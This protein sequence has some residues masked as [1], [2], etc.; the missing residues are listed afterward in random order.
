MVKMDRNLQV[1]SER[2]ENWAARITACRGSGMTVRAWCQENGFSE[3]T[4]Y[5]WQRR[6]FHA[7]SE[8]QQP[9]RQPAFVEIAPTQNVRPSGGVAVT[10]RIAGA[11][12]DIY[13]GADAVTT[14][15]VLRV[16]K[17]C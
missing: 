12:A 11:E 2:L 13:S 17:S 4:Y 10:V 3:K 15:T 6:L 1:M 14:E 8:Q 5:Y 16:L 9:I 7:L